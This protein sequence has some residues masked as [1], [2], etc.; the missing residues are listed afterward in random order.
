MIPAKFTVNK[1]KSDG[2]R[3]EEGV[4]PVNIYYRA[5]K[6]LEEIYIDHYSNQSWR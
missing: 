4:L 6:M 1:N 2:T 3:K 5:V